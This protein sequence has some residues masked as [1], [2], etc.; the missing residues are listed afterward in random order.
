MSALPDYSQSLETESPPIVSRTSEAWFVIIV[1]VLVT[2]ALL[3]AGSIGGKT[4]GIVFPLGS[5]VVAWFLY[6]RYPTFYIGFVWWLIFLVCLVRRLA[7]FRM[8]AF[9]DSSTI[10]LAPYLAILV[11]GH[12]LYFN[13]PKVKEKGTLPFALALASVL[14]G[15]CVGLLYPGISPIKVTVALLGWI[16]PILFG[17]YFYINWQRYPAYSRVTRNTFLWGAL[18]MGVY[19]VYQYVVA[20]EWDCLWLIGSGMGSSAGLPVPY[21]MRVW[22]TLNSMGVYADVIATALLVLPS[23]NSPITLP[24]AVFGGLSLLFTSVRT[25]WLGWMTG[26]LF[27][28]TALSPKHQM[29]IV[30]GGLILALFIVPVVSMEPFSTNLSKRFNSLSDLENDNSAQVRKEVY[31]QFFSSGIYNALGEGIGVNEV[32][33]SGPLSFLLDL[34]WIGSI[35]YVGALSLSIITLLRNI[36]KH[37]DLFIKV[38]CAILVKSMFFFLAARITVG[39]TGIIIW[40]FLGVAMAGQKYLQHRK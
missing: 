38:S 36:K 13:L 31:K 23:C 3:S 15:Y 37:S 26:M 9:T 33:D 20:P 28:S 19:G 14:Y 1:F 32:V 24:A 16:T 2:F 8:G 21:G 6:F 18:V 25:G 7:D 10:L 11:C 12:T 17:H 4:L 5:F 27:V 29:R 35:P 39:V 22:S 40:G 30:V 34:G